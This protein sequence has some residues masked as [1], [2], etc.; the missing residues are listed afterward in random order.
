MSNT[1]ELTERELQLRDAQNY[2][3]GWLEGFMDCLVERKRIEAENELLTELEKMPV[4]E[5][6]Q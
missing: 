3:N 4:N 6:V 2:A 5:V 1:K